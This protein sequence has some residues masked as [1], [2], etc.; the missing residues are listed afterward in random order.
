MMRSEES[1]GSAYEKSTRRAEL[2]KS[3]VLPN[4]FR[5]GLIVLG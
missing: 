3:P 5:K 2:E 1:C 4:L